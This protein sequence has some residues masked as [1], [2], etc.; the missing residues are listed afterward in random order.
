MTVLEIQ[1]PQF[2][3][4]TFSKIFSAMEDLSM[5]LL[6]VKIY[7]QQLQW[8]CFFLFFSK[9]IRIPLFSRSKRRLK[10]I[11]QQQ[12]IFKKSFYYGTI[13][14]VSKLH[15]TVFSGGQVKCVFLYGSNNSGS[16]CSGMT[17]WHK[18]KITVWEGHLFKQKFIYGSFGF[19]STLRKKVFSG[20]PVK[21][22][23]LYGLNNSDSVVF[24]NAAFGE[25][26][27]HSVRTTP[28]QKRFLL[29]KFWIC[30]YRT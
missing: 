4:E 1:R 12:H 5:R 21:W 3:K 23:F 25:I 29:E 13:R 17:V 6:Y 20:A 10:I 16:A 27:D 15:K 8:M 30:V 26:K 18:S 7:F 24:G 14:Y 28:F 19:V 11:V 2:N 22:I 9:T